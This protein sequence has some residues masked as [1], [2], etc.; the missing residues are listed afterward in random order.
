MTYYV[1][2]CFCRNKVIKVQ[3]F[4]W[5]KTYSQFDQL[6]SMV[7]IQ[8]ME[9]P[10]S[11]SSVPA[12]TTL[13]TEGWNH[14][15][16]DTSGRW[17]TMPKLASQPSPGE[18]TLEKRDGTVEEP[19]ILHPDKPHPIHTPS[20]LNHTVSTNNQPSPPSTTNHQ[21]SIIINPSVDPR[22]AQGHA[23][24]R[25]GQLPLLHQVLGLGRNPQLD[26]QLGI[27]GG[28]L[29]WAVRQKWSLSHLPHDLCRFLP[30]NKT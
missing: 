15:R 12:C 24:R 5:I 27:E 21:P 19:Q 29:W 23:S 4:F 8:I 10:K 2:I 1:T 11:L 18:K 9:T 6:E 28:V 26:V 7:G 14:G 17:S 3:H 22:L 20:I 13:P 30:K 25:T 16:V